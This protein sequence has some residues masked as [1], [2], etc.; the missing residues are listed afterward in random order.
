MC[1]SSHRD[2]ENTATLNQGPGL[3]REVKVTC[4][5][6]HIPSSPS[7]RIGLSTNLQAT[8]ATKFKC[9]FYVSKKR[10]VSV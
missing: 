7:D 8:E 10:L 2:F 9:A 3:R 4:L 1:P 6:L 5:S